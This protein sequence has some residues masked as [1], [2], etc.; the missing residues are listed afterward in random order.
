MTQKWLQNVRKHQMR[1]RTPNSPIGLE[2]ER[3][4]CPGGWKHRHHRRGRWGFVTG[5]GV[6][7]GGGGGRHHRASSS[8]V[9]GVDVVVSG[10]ICRVVIRT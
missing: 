10:K 9:L 2:I 3:A 8:S 1:T 5:G 4:K 6:F 7:A